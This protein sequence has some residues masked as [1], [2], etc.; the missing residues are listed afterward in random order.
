MFDKVVYGFC[1]GSLEEWA[2]QEP[3]LIEEH[4]LNHNMKP[5]II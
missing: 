1:K 5:C 2:V 3:N 4:S